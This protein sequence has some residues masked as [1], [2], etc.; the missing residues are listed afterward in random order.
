MQRAKM[1]E[2]LLATLKVGMILYK[3]I[4][5]D[6]LDTMPYKTVVLGNISEINRVFGCEKWAEELGQISVRH[7]AL[8]EEARVAF[9][10]R[11]RRLR[12][13]ADPESAE[14]R[15]AMLESIRDANT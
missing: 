6:F 11:R 4:I 7:C 2:I 14:I 5:Q 3:K 9:E 15:G 10:S 12:V 1:M 8:A 13:L